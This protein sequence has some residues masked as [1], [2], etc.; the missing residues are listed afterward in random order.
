MSRTWRVELLGV[1]T[2]SHFQPINI[3]S[4]KALD[5]L[6]EVTLSLWKHGLPVTFWPH[7]RSQTKDYR[8]LLLPPY[9]FSKTRHWVELKEPERRSDIE[10]T[11]NSLKD[12]PSRGLW[13]FFE[14][15][16][17]SKNK[18]RFRVNTTTQEFEEYVKGHTIA[19]AA[20]LCPSTLQLDIVIDALMSIR[21]D[22]AAES[23]QPQLRDLE[24]H[25][26]M[27]SDAS[28]TVWLDVEMGNTAA[29]VWHFKMASN[30][31]ETN[32]T[33]TLHVSGRIL[34]RSIDDAQLHR[35]F[36]RYEYLSE[37]R[38][39]LQLLDGNDAPEMI[40]GRNIYR[41]F[42][43]T[44]GYGEPY[45]GLQ[46]I[47]GVDRQSTGQSAGRVVKSYR[48]KTWLDTLLADS[49]C[50][51]AGIFV[52]CMTDTPETD[53]C[54]STKIEQWIRS[55]KLRPDDSRPEVW[56]VLALHRRPSDREF[57]SDVFVFDSRNGAL[58]E[59][60]LG[61]GY[62]RVSRTGLGKMLIRLTTGASV[63][64]VKATMSMSSPSSAPVP[65]GVQATGEKQESNQ[66]SRTDI[67]NSVRTLLA[68]V[69]GLEPHKIKTD[70][71]LPDI[72]IDSLVGMELTREIE[73]MFKCKIDAA[74][75]MDVVDFQNLTKAIRAAL[76]EETE[77]SSDSED[78]SKSSVSTDVNRYANGSM[79]PVTDEEVLES[80]S[81]PSKNT[82]D[83][84]IATLTP[85]EET[86]E[87]S[88]TVI[89]E[90]I[91]ESKQATDDFIAENHF[92]GYAEHVL[93]RQTE[94][95]V[96]YVI[97][98]FQ[99]LGCCLRST[100]P[101]SVLPRVHHLPKHQKF[102]NYC[103]EKLLHKEAHLIDI[104]GSRIIRT[105]VPLPTKSADDM[106]RDLIEDFP[107]HAN[108]HRLIYYIGSRLAECLSGET[109]GVQLIFGSIEGRELVS[110]LYG[111]SPIN[112]TFL[113]QMEDFVQRLLSKLPKQ[114]PIKI[115]EMGAG[116][117]GTTAGM[118]TLLDKLDIPV[119]YTF[120]DLSPSL[121]AAARKRFKHY[122]F[123]KFRTH[124][125]EKPPAL[126]LI[127][128]QHIIIANNCV[129]ATRSLSN[130]T[131]NIH[132]VLRPNG[133]LMMVE[134]TDTLFWVDLVFGIL[135][136]WWLFEDD[137]DH[138]VAH[139]AL[140]KQ[141][142]QSA[143]YGHVDWTE[144]R[145]PEANL[146]RIIIALASEPPNV[147]LPQQPTQKSMTDLAVRRA[148]VD[149]YV[150]T[151][152]RGLD[153][154]IETTGP[155]G[156]PETCVLVTGAT[157]SLGSHMVA[158][159]AQLPTV[160][161]VICLNR[162]STIRPGFLRQQ[163]AMESRGISLD[164]AAWS[165]LKVFETDTASASLG[166]PD[167]DYQEMVRSV[168]H[169]VHNAWPM[170]INR[171]TKSF[172]PQFK[173]MR[174]L[175]RLAREASC[176]RPAG[177]KVGFQF[178]SSIATVG[179]YP[180]WTGRSRVPEERMTIE[181]VLP[182]GYGDAKFVCERM[183]DETLHKIV[184]ASV[185]WR[186]VSGR[187]PAQRPAGIGIRSSIWRS[188]SSPRRLSTLFRSSK[189]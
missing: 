176:K 113:K 164:K 31:Q 73:A 14:Y 60:I 46:K 147:C 1:P 74:A 15:Q 89:L 177:H 3:T 124:D 112:M 20:P 68:S 36:E 61:I 91:G 37:Y 126:D 32:S 129:H 101:G 26:P 189:A 110:G 153:S 111:R 98:A 40:Q 13:T 148:A 58:L 48:G 2:D 22:Y 50:Q 133:F 8:P 21:P 7:H 166:L 44:V 87:L 143:G 4:D 65:N 107:D 42:A 53:I 29:H 152:T 43:S 97:E 77:G 141:S 169:I 154:P 23:C 104:Q 71:S 16:D 17:A 79:T 186:S 66:S 83:Q 62:Q 184:R 76:G 92:G 127:Q 34:F 157:G 12:E 146:Q 106:F 96:A 179:Q 168:T 81:V 84:Q 39:C 88:P 135:E 130:S 131:R 35:D 105:A 134:M 41:T 85:P 149:E 173:V 86:T 175:I 132:Q 121:V 125:I 33:T 167:S 185:P 64:P 181:S 80:S 118:A 24:N 78:E 136:G 72:G 172:E 161:T 47:V 120:T 6:T 159:F 162:R 10:G 151:Y 122:D 57:V 180:L 82:S 116:T 128:S 156:K 93:P 160:T 63:E 188:C 56:D 90:A 137:R 155:V 119:E 54:I 30:A 19:Q 5:Y 27:C 171:S 145:R 25:A 150:H 139:E 52:N 103:R 102:V 115:L 183:L 70:T 140:W 158:H 138:V 45:R 114:G 11:G 59:V 174:N 94:L 55:P 67:E 100:E 38:K 75:M 117:G 49:F 95:C 18:A 99:K 182:S 163:Q 51:V 144:G 69:S 142:L 170:S 178:I 108:D 28:K 165:K 9:Q 187:S 123:M 109:D